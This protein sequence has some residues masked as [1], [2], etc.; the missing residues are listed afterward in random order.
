MTIGSK[1][2]IILSFIIVIA[3][4]SLH[5]NTN[6]QYQQP[7]HWLTG[8]PISAYHMQTSAYQ[9]YDNSLTAI[10]NTTTTTP[11]NT[12]N[13]DQLPLANLTQQDCKTVTQ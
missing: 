9:I 3:I 13:T 10:L 7:L 4:N 8:M 2:T 6:H 12:A 11:P 5:I 1:P